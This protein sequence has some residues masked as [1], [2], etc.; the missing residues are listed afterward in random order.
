MFKVAAPIAL[1][2]A[3]AACGGGGSS[4]GPASPPGGNSSGPPSLPSSVTAQSGGT[5]GTDNI[6]SPDDGDGASG[7]N[8]QTVDGI[9]CNPTMSEADYHIHVFVGILANGSLV[10][11]PDGMGMK[12]PGADS[13]G[14]TGTATCFYYLH[15][16]DAT[17]IVHV[18]DPSTASRT[19]S[20]HTFGQFLDIWGQPLTSSGLGPFSGSVKVYTSGAVYRGQGPQ[21]VSNSTYAQYSGDPRNIALYGHE[22]IWIE[23]GPT[24]VAPQSLPGVNFTY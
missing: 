3:L 24:F 15:T 4:S 8:G 23:I 5:I 2:F 9:P 14:V 18:E 19:T 7:G 6:F 10:A 12:N 20:L 16:H 21:T 13:S 1:L 22:V 11:L 17:G